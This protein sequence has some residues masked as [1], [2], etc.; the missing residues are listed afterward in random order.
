MHLPQMLAVSMADSRSR[1]VDRARRAGRLASRQIAEFRKRAGFL[2]ELK[3]FIRESLFAVLLSLV[4]VVMAGVL[5]SSMRE[6]LLLLPG[7][8]LLVPGALAMRGNIYASL[9]ARLGTAL[10]TGQLS[11]QGGNSNILREE[12]LVV[13]VQT[14]MGSL[15]LAIVGRVTAILLEIP[16]VSIVDLAVT[17]MV[18]ALMAG[19]I[20]LFVTVQVAMSAHRRGWDPDNVTAP[21]ISAVADLVSIPFLLGAAM[22]V[23]WMPGWAT[24]SVFIVLIL[25]MFLLVNI[26]VRGDHER[27]SSV[28]AAS[29]PVLLA[30]LLVVL[31]P[32][33]MLERM[34]E[35][36]VDNPAILIL[37]PPFVA[38]AGNLGAILASRLSS[39]AHLGLITLQGRPD[40]L[41]YQNL[42][43]ITLLAVLTFGALGVL[44]HWTAILIG[45]PSPG[46]GTL[47][48]ITLVGG[49]V[50]TMAT[51]LAAYKVTAY[52][53]VRGDDPD[54]VV[55]PIITSTMDALGTALVVLLFMTMVLDTMPGF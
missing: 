23:V 17:A 5:F 32:A 19:A 9:G 2:W 44:T 39:A 20:E 50:V 3:S 15:F 22:L 8:T 47:L 38:V 31:I 7:L 10:H 12:V 27:A 43:V 33:V 42:G 46:L 41:V 49:L 11:P 35:E 1:A 14:L 52:T 25:V 37:I 29:I 48:T 28:L 4:I 16:T 36:L 13:M 55:I 26:I 18:G 30:V 54:N 51:S 34:V 24:M 6:A 53:F 21:V 45:V 40:R